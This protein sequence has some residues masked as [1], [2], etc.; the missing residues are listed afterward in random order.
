[1]FI[2]E[3]N[4]RYLGVKQNFFYS[5]TNWS[6]MLSSGA[7]FDRPDS[8]WVKCTYLHIKYTTLFY[9]IS[10][11]FF[12]FHTSAPVIYSNYIYVYD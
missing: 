4:K 1:M 2:S 12:Y 9:P 11:P 3:I 8:I 5:F 7:S 6:F 10:D